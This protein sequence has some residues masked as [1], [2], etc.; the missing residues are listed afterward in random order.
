M[1]A[2][3]LVTGS[4]AAFCQSFR[5]A[6]V[7][8]IQAPSQK[9]FD[10]AKAAVYEELSARTDLD[11]AFFLGDLSME[12]SEILAGTAA[13]FKSWS[14]PVYAVPGNHD[15][16][17]EKMGPRS[18]DT[19]ERVFGKPDTT[20]VMKGVRF[21]LV[22]NVRTGFEREGKDYVG[23]FN[24]SQKEWLDGVLETCFEGRTFLLSHIALKSCV[25][26]DSL[27]A[28][29]TPDKVSMLLCAH[30]HTASRGK[31]NDIET[32]DA[33]APY[34]RKWKKDKASDLMA[35][36]TPRG[37]FIFTVRPEAPESE[38]LEIEFHSVVKEYPSPAYACIDEE[39]RLVVNVYGG[40]KSGTLTAGGRKMTWQKMPD[41]RIGKDKN[42]RHVWILEDS[43]VHP[44]DELP[45]DY[46]DKH[47]R[48]HQTIRIN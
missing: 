41:P 33:G 38:W 42:S 25:G 10:M 47:L 46:R 14:F 30:T 3:L 7:G 26:R 44:G 36:G 22:N 29:V 37:Y 20:F 8:D 11:A 18:L 2:A 1:T 23:G 21:I 13:L 35:C 19:W 43:K 5:F 9:E 24:D 17:G 15:R 39:G 16:D 32:F 4:A 34:A 40:V 12:N 6:V 27:A 45:L 48:F 28:G 31:W